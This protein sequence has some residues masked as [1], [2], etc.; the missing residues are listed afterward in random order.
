[1]HGRTGRLFP[2]L[3]LLAAIVAGFALAACGN[4]EDVTITQ[5]AEET[6][7]DATT[8]DTASTTTVTET[9]E[10]STT[11]DSAPPDDEGGTA[12]VPSD[13]ESCGS[14]VF[15]E[16]G[17]TSC[18]FGLNVAD[19]YFSAGGGSFE[20]FSPTTGESY[21]MSCSGG[22]PITCTGGNNAVVYIAAS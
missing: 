14:G 20:S 6:T 19:D 5:S 16:S 4:S 13:A 18:A 1:V 2:L 21:T 9:T 3:G 17:S 11:D 12:G 10:T 22:S 8:E 7:E 15:V